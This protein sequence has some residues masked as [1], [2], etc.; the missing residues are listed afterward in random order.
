MLPQNHRNN[1]PHLSTRPWSRGAPFRC[2]A[3]SAAVCLTVL[4]PAASATQT[5]RVESQSSHS[6]T[7]IEWN[8]NTAA[9]DPGSHQ[10]V[11]TA[12]SAFEKQNP[13]WSIDNIEMSLPDLTEKLPLALASAASSPAV[14]QSNNGYTSMGHLVADDELLPLTKY[15]Q[16][17]HWDTMLGANLLRYMRFTSNG[18]SYGSGN[19]YGVPW[20][21]SV[22]GVFYNKALLAKAKLPI[23]TS[24]AQINADLPLLKA[25][26]ITPIAYSSG[27]PTAYNNLHLFYILAD[28]YTP[29]S[30]SNNFLFHTGP[31]PSIDVPGY[32]KA[33]ETML[34]WTK[35]GYFPQGF[36]GL[37]GAQ[38]LSLFTSG[39]AAFLFEGA[40]YLGNAESGLGAN[41]GIWIP[42]TTD[43][44]ADDGWTIP[45][46]SPYPD[47]AAAFLNAVIGPQAQACQLK[48][49]NIPVVAPSAMALAAVPPVQRA[50][51]T[52]ADQRLRAQQVVPP[53]DWATPGLLDQLVASLQELQAGQV[54]PANMM[55]QIQSDYDTYWSGQ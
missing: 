30:T 28:E 2:A 34:T 46:Y 49:G 15:V 33:A 38:S 51:V 32:I 3:I 18:K 29:A 13:H 48:Q 41:A 21:V 10:C 50:A 45:R 52:G 36:T 37:S 55:S 43:G 40:W 39:K 7:L 47:A 24:W 22:F 6:T 16:K 44:A 4:A 12:I 27:Q 23:P 14:T 31:K 9:Q 8:Q 1:S 54:T 26:G 53:L 35:D 42:P 11:P 19:V 17:Y 20:R 25:A 5:P